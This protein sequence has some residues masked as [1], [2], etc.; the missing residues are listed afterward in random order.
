VLLSRTLN[1]T[2]GQQPEVRVQFSVTNKV[3]N[4]FF[5]S[6]YSR[7][8][9]IILTTFCHEKIENEK[10]EEQM[11]GHEEQMNEEMKNK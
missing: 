2:L 1:R 3:L 11:N 7:V 8:E 9:S 6:H 4:I 5:T 10:N